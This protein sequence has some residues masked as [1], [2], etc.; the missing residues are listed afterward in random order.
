LRLKDEQIM[1]ASRR[2]ADF[3]VMHLVEE[4]DG[5]K[6]PMLV[7]IDPKVKPLVARR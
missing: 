1:N 7:K 6:M 2:A 3:V 4:G 5:V